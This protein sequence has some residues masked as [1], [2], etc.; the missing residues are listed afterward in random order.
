MKDKVA[1]RNDFR[2][3]S[4]RKGR[5]TMTHQKSPVPTN[6][7]KQENANKEPF[8]QQQTSIIRDITTYYNSRD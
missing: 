5:T 7:K 8:E 2:F 3:T 4:M 6:G 1:N